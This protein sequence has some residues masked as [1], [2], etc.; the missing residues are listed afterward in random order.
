M[1]L[2]RIKYFQQYKGVCL[3][4]LKII[5]GFDLEYSHN[6]KFWRENFNF[7]FRDFVMSI[8]K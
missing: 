4:L 7:F 2:H 5:S 3:L 6:I 8:N 1:K